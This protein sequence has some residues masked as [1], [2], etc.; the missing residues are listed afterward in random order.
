MVQK[1]ENKHNPLKI[2][3][4]AGGFSW[5]WAK[6][7]R[8]CRLHIGQAWCRVGLYRNHSIKPFLTQKL[9]E[10]ARCWWMEGDM[11]VASRSLFRRTTGVVGLG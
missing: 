4:A 7:R 6:A 9:Q 2:N 8:W 10:H 1:A 5:R 3:P 11:V